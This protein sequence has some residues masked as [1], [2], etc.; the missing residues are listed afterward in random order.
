[1]VRSLLFIGTYPAVNASLSDFS[2]QWTH[3]LKHNEDDAGINA[4]IAKDIDDIQAAYQYC[5]Y[6]LSGEG[7]FTD[8]DCARWLSEI[9]VGG[10]CCA[11]RTNIG[12]MISKKAIIENPAFAKCIQ[13]LR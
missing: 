5:V 6:Y 1:M 7:K 13:L 10:P 3:W 11:L 12:R 2:E 9:Y 4:L 8:E